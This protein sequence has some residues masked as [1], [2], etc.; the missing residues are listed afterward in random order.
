M[1]HKVITDPTIWIYS[2]DILICGVGFIIFIWWW[3]R[4][5][6]ASEV[7]AYIT[8]LFLAIVMERVVAL[9]L[10]FLIYYDLERAEKAIH[11]FSWCVRT[12][13]GTL[14]MLLMV[15]RM[16]TRACRT[17]RLER[18]YRYSEEAECTEAVLTVGEEGGKDGAEK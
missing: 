12:I 11:S 14:I 3:I 5:R 4:Q 10:R 6:T 17:L 13:P 7:Y 1:F 2:A 15:V 9:S 8:F 16:M 18:K